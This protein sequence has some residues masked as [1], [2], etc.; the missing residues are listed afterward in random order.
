MFAHPPLE[1]ARKVLIVGVFSSL[2]L[3]FI[4]QFVGCFFTEYY[5]RTYVSRNHSIAL[6]TL[7]VIFSTIYYI[8]NTSNFLFYIS[9]TSICLPLTHSRLPIDPRH[10]NCPPLTYTLRL[11]THYTFHLQGQPFTLQYHISHNH[12]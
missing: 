10:H 4:L 7:F 8:L 12:L 3:P 6:T 11:A 2:L 1:E 9:R 5:E